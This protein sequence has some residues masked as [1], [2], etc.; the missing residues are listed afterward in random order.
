MLV[1][2]ELPGQIFQTQMTLEQCGKLAASFLVRPLRGPDRIPECSLC[3]EVVECSKCPLGAM[4]SARFVGCQAAMASIWAALGTFGSLSRARQGVHRNRTCAERA[5]AKQA[6]GR[7]RRW[8]RRHVLIDG[9]PA[10]VQEVYRQWA[11]SE[12][13]KECGMQ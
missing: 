10:N 3:Q 5:E 6:L 4:R 1:E 8:I 2:I 7:V 12:G 9:K 13:A 11:K